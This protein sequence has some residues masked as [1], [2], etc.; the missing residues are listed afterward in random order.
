MWRVR[1]LSGFQLTGAHSASTKHDYSAQVIYKSESSVLASDD[2]PLKKDPSNFPHQNSI[3]FVGLRKLDRNFIIIVSVLF[4]IVAMPFIALG[5]LSLGGFDSVLWSHLNNTILW[6]AI[7]STL[8]LMLGVGV[9]V[10]LTGV[11][12][13]WLVTVCRFP[14]RSLLSFALLLPLAL[15]TYVSAFAYIEALGFTGPVQTGIRELFG[16]TS[17]R[18]YWFPDY[19]T[20]TGAIFV[21]SAVLYPYVYLTTRA[22]FAMQTESAFDASRTLGVGP[23]QLFFRVA[24]PMARPAIIVGVALA[25]META[26]D[27]GAVEFFGVRT[28]T[29]TIYDVWLNRSS[30]ATASQIACLFLSLIILLLWL[31]RH[32]R[33]AQRLFQSC[34]KT[35]S[36]KPFQLRGLRAFAAI[37]VCA[38][39]VLIGFI[40]PVIVLAESAIAYVA[41]DGFAALLTPMA[42]SLFLAIVATVVLIMIGCFFAYLTNSLPTPLCDLLVRL[43]TL[44]YAVPGVILAVGILIPLA[45]FDNA[46]DSFMRGT[47]DI[48]T[49]L[50]LSGTT[51]ALIYAYCIRFLPMAYG[52]CDNGFQRLTP[53]FGFA[54]RTLGR[55][56]IAVLYEVYFPLLRPAI[57]TG[58][59]LVFVDCMKELPATLLLRPF[60]YETLSTRIY[61]AASLELFEEGALPSLAIIVVGLL[62]VLLLSMQDRQNN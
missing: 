7:R 26:N 38:L 2:F 32:A 6:S 31:E 55:S 21:M 8:Y 24:L 51:F 54:G 30:L 60:N 42:N 10:T 59:I 29:T 23:F 57:I 46:F 36:F 19:R 43:T 39:P 37:I 62:P 15:P 48:K 16:Y 11:A 12:T 52:A 13:A 27:I 56:Q 18:E 1:T 41:I 25:L 22:S 3:R 50:L 47:F 5:V 20:S 33:Q 61:E 49:G 17:I 58:A 9:V 14:G 4:A 45:T 34:G 44:G 28:L 35:T 40:V 53:N